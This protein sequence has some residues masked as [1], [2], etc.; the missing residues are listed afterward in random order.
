MVRA[1]RRPR[2]AA[3]VLNQDPH[4]SPTAGTGSS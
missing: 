2:I 3:V 4:P 1:E